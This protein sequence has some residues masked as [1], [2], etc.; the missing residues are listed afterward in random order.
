MGIVHALVSFGLMMELGNACKHSALCYAV[1][2]SLLANSVSE[3]WKA[4]VRPWGGY[5][6]P[7]LY[8]KASVW[9]RLCFKQHVLGCAHLCAQWKKFF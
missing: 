8:C 1:R 2:T 7:V 3:L 4:A 6:N 9:F 5:K